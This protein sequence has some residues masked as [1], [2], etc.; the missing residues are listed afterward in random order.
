MWVG[1]GISILGFLVELLAVSQA[2]LQSQKS[3]AQQA[4]KKR[5]TVGEPTEVRFLYKM[6]HLPEQ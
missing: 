3:G 4:N 1:K 2:T 6:N 5:V